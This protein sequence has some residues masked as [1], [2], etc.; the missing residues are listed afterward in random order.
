MKKTH[1]LIKKLVMFS[2]L[3]ILFCVS[4]FSS[5]FAQEKGDFFGGDRSTRFG[6]KGG[7]N[8]SQ[9]YVDKV[10]GNTERSNGAGM[11]GFLL[12]HL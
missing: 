4:S 8:V 5:A 9:L 3:L 11:Q 7:L 12:R 10:D 6:F 1:F 2:F